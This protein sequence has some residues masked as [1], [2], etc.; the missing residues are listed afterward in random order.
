[1]ETRYPDERLL[2]EASDL[3]KTE[4]LALGI[5]GYRPTKID[6]RRTGGVNPPRPNY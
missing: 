2:Q 5:L 1:M 4:R 3:G 6:S